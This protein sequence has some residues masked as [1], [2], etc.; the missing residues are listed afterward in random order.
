MAKGQQG[1]RRPATKF[2]QLQKKMLKNRTPVQPP[3][4]PPGPKKTGGR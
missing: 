2:P 3:K 4:A 1:A